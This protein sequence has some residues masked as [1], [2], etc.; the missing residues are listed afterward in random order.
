MEDLIGI[1]FIIRLEDEDEIQRSGFNAMQPVVQVSPNLCPSLLPAV[2]AVREIWPLFFSS[3]PIIR[4][5][6]FNIP[7]PKKGPCDA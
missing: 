1:V 2:N 3:G 6:I 7:C 5:I 4:K